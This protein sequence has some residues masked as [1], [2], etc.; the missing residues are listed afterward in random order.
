MIHEK[1]LPTGVIVTNN[2][3]VLEVMT[4]EEKQNQEKVKGITLF[5]FLKLKYF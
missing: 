5:Q 2:K 4:P 1:K 3:G